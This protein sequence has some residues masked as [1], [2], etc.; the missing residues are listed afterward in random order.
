MGAFL[1]VVFDLIYFKLTCNCIEEVVRY[2]LTVVDKT[3]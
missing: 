3:E 2:P 1:E